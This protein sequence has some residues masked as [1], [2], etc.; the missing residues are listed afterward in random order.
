MLSLVPIAI[1]YIINV[2][3][4]AIVT[5]SFKPALLYLAFL[6]T[7]SVQITSLTWRLIKFSLLLLGAEIALPQTFLSVAAVIVYILDFVVFICAFFVVP[8]KVL[9][10]F[11]SHLV[12]SKEMDRGIYMQIVLLFLLIV[13][14]VIFTLVTKIEIIELVKQKMNSLFATTNAQ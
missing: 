2:F 3:A 5:K 12:S 4:W 8:L 7:A 1:F 13:I 10:R 6:Y 9:R 11:A 14:G